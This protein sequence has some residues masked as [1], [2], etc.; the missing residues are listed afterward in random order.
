M[1]PATVFHTCQ[2][3]PE[4]LQGDLREEL[5]AA[6]LRDVVEGK[7]DPVYQDPR[8]FFENTYPTEG[9]KALLA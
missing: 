3:R 5:F 2:P 4:V 7:A 6:R 9:L 1:C 8:R